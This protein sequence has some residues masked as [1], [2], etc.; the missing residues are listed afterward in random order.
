MPKNNNNFSNSHFWRTY[1]VQHTINH[2]SKYLDFANFS[3]EETEA[4]RE[5][6]TQPM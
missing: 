2:Y 1:Y 5:F 4:E 6:M 3:E